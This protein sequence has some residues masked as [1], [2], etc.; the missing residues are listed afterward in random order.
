MIGALLTEGKIDLLTN[1]IRVGFLEVEPINGRE[2]YTV[3]TKQSFDEFDE[4]NKR[5]DKE[6]FPWEEELENIFVHDGQPKHNQGMRMHGSEGSHFQNAF[7]NDRMIEGSSEWEREENRRVI[8][9]IGCYS[10]IDT[11]WKFCP[12]CGKTVK[13]EEVSDEIEQT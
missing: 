3:S 12:C 11:S 8:T 10:E 9:C 2:T 4:S 13:E 5:I 1:K 7:L 6:Q